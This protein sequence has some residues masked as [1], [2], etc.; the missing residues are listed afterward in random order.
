MTSF[1]PP[2]DAIALCIFAASWLAYGAV[3][4]RAV[5]T[6]VGLAERMHASR[7][8]WM[9]QMAGRDVRMV[10]TAI[11]GSLQNGTAFFASTSLIAIGGSLTLMRAA[12][13][14]LRMFADL[15]LGFAV[16]RALWEIKTI[17]L[18][19][20][21]G[22]AFFKFAWAYRLFNYSAILIG[23]TPPA[24]SPDAEARDRAADRAARMM[25]AAGTSFAA[26]QRAFFF[27]FAYLGWFLGPYALVVTTALIV[28]VIWRRQ[29][30]SDAVE[31]LR[32]EA[33]P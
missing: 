3:L 4:N 11:M 12:D 16:T 23:A 32:S 24:S 31:A 8:A 13:D 17:G 21:Y 22:Y 1:L 18:A 27:S 6:R 28:T 20:I 10:D 26:G 5:R 33:P 9:H 2:L 19:S 14:V 25:I 29:F 7:V 15:P 30:R